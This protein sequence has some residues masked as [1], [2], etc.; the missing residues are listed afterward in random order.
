M[1]T[2]SF[3]ML[4]FWTI[5]YKTRA[6]LWPICHNK[7]FPASQTSFLQLSALTVLAGLLPKLLIA[8]LNHMQME[9]N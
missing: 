2:P 5:L 9:D 7:L 4:H 1:S 3:L 6:F 8:L